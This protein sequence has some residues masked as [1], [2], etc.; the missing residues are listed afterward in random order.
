MK[1]KRTSIYVKTIDEDG[2]AINNSELQITDEQGNV[3]VE[4]TNTQ[5]VQEVQKLEVGKI[6]ILKEKRPVDG[7]VTIEEIMFSI[8]SN[9]DLTEQ[10]S[11]E[12][13]TLEAIHYKTKVQ[14]QLVDGVNKDPIDGIELVIK[15]EEGNEVATLNIEAKDNS[16]EENT[17]DT[18][19]E[20]IEDIIEKL[21]VGTYTIESTKMPYGYK[22][23]N[24]NITIKDEQGLQKLVIEAEREEFDLQV[25]EWLVKIE[26]NQ[27][28]EYENTNYENKMKKVDIKDKKIST[29][30]IRITYKIKVSNP[31]KI[32]GE[33]GKVEVTIPSGMKF[34]AS[35]NKAYWNVENGKVVTYGLAGREIPEGAYA[36]IELVLRWKNGLENF[37]TKQVE[38]RILETKS[39]IGFEE[40]NTE[41]NTAQIEV[42]IGVSTGEMNLVYICWILLVILILI[43]I[44]VSRKTKIKKFGLKDR[45]LKYSKKK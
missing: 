14:I 39:D 45:T 31:G 36:E 23:L 17:D 33:V 43:E 22:K 20:T 44:L 6:Y 35:D 2:N 24:T 16:N 11:D 41:N 7:Y 8:Q 40:T 30:D 4:W 21:P 37:G 9:G 5:E 10:T 34:D 18:V 19:E 25:E 38:A 15:D 42:I 13:N 29:E 26:R 12:Y 27:K 1:R 32:T 28:T 3:L